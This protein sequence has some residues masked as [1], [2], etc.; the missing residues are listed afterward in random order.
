MN[1]QPVYLS[2]PG[3][4]SALGSGA[5]AH[6]AGL[7]TALP[8][9]V[10]QQADISGITRRF[11]L[12]TTP[13]RDF[14]ANLPDHY[15]SRTNHLLWHALA[16]IEH[17]IQTA[18]TRYGAA[19]VAVVLGTSTAGVDENIPLFRHVAQGGSW[20]DKPFL[21]TPQCMNAAADFVAA[22]YGLQGMRY[23]VSTA[24]TS[25]A[26]ALMAAARM[27]RMGL[28]DA[29]ICG[30][31]DNLSPLTVH[32]FA[33]L[34]V[35]SPDIARPFSAQRDGINLGEAAA[36]FVMT[37]EPDRFGE[38]IALLG[39]GASSDAHHMS[40]PDPEGKGAAA[41]FQTALNHAGL[42]SD[43]IGWINAHGTGTPLNDQMESRAISA[44]FGSRTPTTSTKPL[45]GHTLAA[46]GALEAAF[47]YLALSRRH[48]P[49]G[50]LPPHHYDGVSDG[51]LPE[52]RLTGAADVWPERRI[53]ASPSFAF[54]GNNS[55]LILGEAFD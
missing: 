47:A 4:V 1:H 17:T 12:A 18:V 43:Q 28:A 53:A 24:C 27:L 48:N 52:I 50:V 40:S 11:G 55:V 32:G 44:V 26:R 13:L 35:L 6:W 33:S 31:V 46:A 5:A 30:G 15:R 45:T 41:A 29:V 2:E 14:P 9:Q 7:C 21:R 19:R 36:V 39:Y 37:R 22:V 8:Q 16:D 51:N 34:E 23:G 42:T 49:N 10:L 20:Y 38:N 54:G 3:M 25:G